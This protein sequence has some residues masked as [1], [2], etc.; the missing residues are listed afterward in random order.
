MKTCFFPTA[1]AL[2]LLALV[3]TMQP[4]RAE[5]S[6]Q[7]ALEDAVM[8]E[9]ERLEGASRYRFY[10]ADEE[11]GRS[12]GGQR[13][14]LQDPDI[15]WSE[16]RIAAETFRGDPVG[17][18]EVIAT[19]VKQRLVVRWDQDEFDIPFIGVQISGDGRS[20]HMA[21]EIIE[22]PYLITAEPESVQRVLFGEA[23]V[24]EGRRTPGAPFTFDDGEVESF[25]P[26]IEL[27]VP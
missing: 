19:T 26:Y 14:F 15:D 11:L 22:F 7:I 24:R 10:L 5:S 3:L 21:A 27:E 9:W 25:G 12:L 2:V 20:G 6:V 16:V 17:E 18:T 1:S 23:V 4:V 13:L 8:V